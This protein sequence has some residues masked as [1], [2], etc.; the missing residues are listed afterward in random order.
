MAFTNYDYSTGLAM[1]GQ[2]VNSWVK[3]Q[4][5]QRAAEAQAAGFDAWANASGAPSLASLG[6]TADASGVPGVPAAPAAPATTL[7][8]FARGDAMGQYA[9]AIQG[10]ESGGRYDIVGPTHPKLGRALGAY[11]VME[12]NVGPWTQEALGRALT[13]DEFLKDPAA[14]DAVFRYKFGQS[15]EKYGNPQDAASVWFTGRPLAQGANAR[16]VLGTTGQG[17]VDKFTAGLGGTPATFAEAVPGSQSPAP[18]PP[19]R[20][21]GGVQVA[22][23][24]PGFAPQM[25]PAR[26]ASDIL[27]SQAQ[28]R[29]GGGPAA[30]PVQMAQASPA[31]AGGPAVSDQQKQVIRGL[32]AN[33]DTRQMG[34]ALWQQALK[35]GEIKMQDLG[36]SVGVFDA[37]GNMLKTIPKT[38]ALMSV[39]EG[40]GIFDPNTKQFVVQPTAKDTSTTDQRNYEEA[41]AGGYTGSFNDW[42]TNIKRAGATNIVQTSEKAQDSKIGGAY[43]DTFNELQKG[44]RD[45]QGQLN[46]FRIMEKLID[47]PEFYSG[48]GANLITTFKRGAASLGIK[49]ADAAAPNELFQKLASQSVLD[50]LGG[51]LGSGV[52]NS[53]VSFM[54]ATTAN[55]TNTPEGN[56]QIIQFGKALAQRQVEISKLAR[57]YAQA[58]GG[59]LDSG[60]DDQLSAFAEANPLI[61]EETKAQAARSASPRQSGSPAVRQAPAPVLDDARAAI[62]RG[63]PRD[64]VIKRLRDNGIDPGGL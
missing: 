50:K 32:L 62:A 6:R 37:R 59:R 60:F 1:L 11:Q 42:L 44:G 26:T 5:E 63:A 38:R 49:D 13:P 34:M 48:N 64:A 27:V 51:S 18:L 29:T 21:D 40:N 17:Y 20:G 23:A 55:L 56:R 15:V 46:T 2:G 25:P 39:T 31:A 57:S 8:T 61:P 33:P 43:G 14:Q 53:D 7:P 10:N 16:D 47:N 22:S 45:A 3:R 28:G 4:D 12:A 35:P 24:D 52:S 58:H 36:D 9:S 54:A 30:A 41:K 19:S